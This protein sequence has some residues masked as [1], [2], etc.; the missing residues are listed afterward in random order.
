MTDSVRLI[1]AI[2]LFGPPLVF[3]AF[4]MVGITVACVSEAVSEARRKGGDA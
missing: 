4:A 1:G 2:L 3:M